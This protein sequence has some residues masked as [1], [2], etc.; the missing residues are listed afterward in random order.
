MNKLYFGE[1]LEYMKTLPDRAVDLVLTDP[2]YGLKITRSGN[3][4][5][6]ATNK[7]RKAT[8]EAWDDQTPTKEYFDEMR[9]V[10]KNQIIFGL[11]FFMEFLPSSRCYI[12]WD[13]RGSLPDVPFSPVELIWTSF[14]KQPKKYV[15]RNHGFIKDS[16]EKRKHP[17][18]KPILLLEKIL[19]DFSK[20]GETVFDPFM[21]SGS[22]GK[23][24]K[25]LNR[26][27]WGCEINPV[28]FD[29]ASEE[30]VC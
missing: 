14:N 1:C 13:K 24:C 20:E 29:W 22:T 12:V 7:S 9:R 21:G 3:N 23:A 6:T 16:K 26:W 11:N 17:T 2:P 30:I 10:S 4:F 18:Q 27:F 15:V 28:Y 25:S 5:G 19:E 8:G